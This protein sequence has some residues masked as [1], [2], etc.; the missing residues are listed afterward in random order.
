MRNIYPKLVESFSKIFSYFLSIS[1]L[2]SLL[3]F[4]NCITNISQFFLKYVRTLQTPATQLWKKRLISVF[5]IVSLSLQSFL[6]NRKLKNRRIIIIIN[7]CIRQ[8]TPSYPS[9]HFIPFCQQSWQHWRTCGVGGAVLLTVRNVASSN[10]LL[11]SIT[12]GRNGH[13]E[14][15]SFATLCLRWFLFGFFENFNFFLLNVSNV[16]EVM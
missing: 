11:I 7:F 12:R 9:C 5:F 4:E 14:I 8:C 16:F 15:K 3:N 13:I 10:F 1:D 2:I 6:I